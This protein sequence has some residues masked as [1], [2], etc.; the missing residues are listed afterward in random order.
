[1]FRLP[2]QTHPSTHA[3]QHR[4]PCIR[5]ASTRR[6]RACCRPHTPSTVRRRGSGH[7]GT[8]SA[9]RR[10]LRTL[11]RGTTHVVK[12]PRPAWNRCISRAGVV[13][14]RVRSTEGRVLRR[15]PR[16]LPR[17]VVGRGDVHIG[18]EA[19]PPADHD[20]GGRHGPEQNRV[21]FVL[22]T[23][24]HELLCGNEVLHHGTHG[25]TRRARTSPEHTN[26]PQKHRTELAAAAP[27]MAEL[28]VANET[29]ALARCG[30]EAYGEGPARAFVADGTPH[31]LT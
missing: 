26:P 4:R 19:G 5:A 2:P 31:M 13:H 20:L 28:A 9:G 6:S 18:D 10:R 25:A 22:P 15:R 24:P 3:P 17:R 29:L 1:M 16:E 8:V 27:S 12:V 11:L 23:G 30:N 7:I 21:V 14:R